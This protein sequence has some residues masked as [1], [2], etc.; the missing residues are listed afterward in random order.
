MAENVSDAKQQVGASAREV[1]IHIAQQLGDIVKHTLG[2]S[3][4]DNMLVDNAKEVVITNDGATIMKESDIDHPVAKVIMDVARTQEEQCFDGTTS[5]I[6]LTGELMQQAKTLL[7]NKIHPTKIS[8]GYQI[9]AIKAEE[10]LLDMGMEANA[11]VL[12]MVAQTAM[13]GK[14][15][16]A[17]KEHLA[18]ICVE[19][20]MAADIEDIN[21]VQRPNGKVMESTAIAGLLID[22]EKLDHVMPDAVES[23]KIG[24]IAA[25]IDIPDYAQQLNVQLND[26]SGV[27]DFID[28]RNAQLVEI[29][30][31]L[32]ATGLNVLFCSREL[33][34]A[35]IEHLASN[36]VYAV[37]RVRRSDMEALANATEGRIVMNIDTFSS[38]DLG[39]AGLLEEVN[40][41]ERPMIKI[42]GTPNEGTVSVLVRAPTH[43]VVEEIK[44]AFDDAI[45][46][47][48]IANEDQSV[49][50]GGGAPYMQL[51]TK[52]KEYA[53][54]VGG[55]EQMAVEAFANA[56][57]VIP[58]TLAA[59]SGLDPIDAMI[60]LRKAHSAEDG[61][62]Y[63]VNV[64]DGTA[65][66]ML[67]EKVVEPKRVVAQA[68]RSAADISA[69]LIRIEL[70]TTAKALSEIGDDDFQF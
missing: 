27:K 47:V 56:L 31:R 67:A 44:R 1:C 58:K 14:S 68:I 39:S 46:V 26:N 37:R 45:G 60:A 15:A 70:I 55:R 11:E 64:N 61:W 51:S 62:K 13:T 2:P 50:P 10:F 32:V 22:G 69:Q 63:G 34:P 6:I 48:S 40:I 59:N 43:H 23:P 36:N 20:A 25:D 35:I 54:T 66:N 38:K 18:D 29:G 28:S 4:L 49:V 7:N 41:G 52:L 19:V 42:T 16:E 33:H 17:D 9:A 5:S 21:I 57:E 24:L 12:D 8:L 30:E 53:A 3:G 65:S